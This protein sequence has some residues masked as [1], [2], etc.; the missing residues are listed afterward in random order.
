MILRGTICSTGEAVEFRLDPAVVANLFS[1]PR[2]MTR[3]Q[4]A[5]HIG[6]SVRTVDGYLHDGMPRIQRVRNGSIWIDPDAAIAWLKGKG[7]A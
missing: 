2:S 3:Q 1:R 5:A 4:F 7:V 6:K